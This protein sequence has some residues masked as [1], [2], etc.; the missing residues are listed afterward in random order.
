MMISSLQFQ[1]EIK[2]ST[3]KTIQLK[4]LRFQF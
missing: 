3:T 4:T 1:F 2:L